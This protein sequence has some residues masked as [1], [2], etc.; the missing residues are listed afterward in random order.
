MASSATPVLRDTNVDRAVANLSRAPHDAKATFKI[1]IGDVCLVENHPM[2][3][4][5]MLSLRRAGGGEDPC[6][7]GCSAPP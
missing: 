7:S 2:Q 6:L 3:V 4:G 1:P 5:V